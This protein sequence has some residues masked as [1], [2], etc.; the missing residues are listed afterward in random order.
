MLHVEHYPGELRGQDLGGGMSLD[1][2]PR[3][4]DPYGSWPTEVMAPGWIELWMRPQGSGPFTV[5]DTG[6]RDTTDRLVLHYD[7]QRFIFEGRVCT[8]FARD[9]TATSFHSEGEARAYVNRLLG[10]LAEI[11]MR[12]DEL[13][14]ACT[15]EQPTSVLAAPIVHSQ[16]LIGVLILGRPTVSP[17]DDEAEKL[18]TIAAELASSVIFSIRHVKLITEENRMVALIALDRVIDEIS[19]H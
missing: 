4:D 15:F 12:R 5:F 16:E 1:T 7:G 19:V 11:D 10:K 8:L 13:A 2:I 9:L 18:L 17:F 14:P 3:M 6:Q